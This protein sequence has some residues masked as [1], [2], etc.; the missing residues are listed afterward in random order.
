MADKVTIKTVAKLANVSHT[1]VSRAL[2]GSPLV[3]EETRKKIQEIAT[4]LDYTPNLNAKAL[5]EKRSYIIAVYF[6]D[7]SN[8]TS[9]SFMSEV[10]HQIREK[11]PKG[12]EI[13]VDSFAALR[14]SGQ[15][16]NLRYDGALVV[17]QEK[18][19]DQF[20]DQL[21]E[22]GKPVVVLNRKVERTDL[23][24]YASDDFSGMENAINYLLRMGHRKIAFITG[25]KGFTS[26]INRKAAFVDVMKK[27][28]VSV[29]EEWMIAGD[30]SIESGYKAMEKIINGGKIP[31]C[32]YASNDDMAIGAIRACNDYGYKVPGQISFMGFDDSIFANYFTPRLTTLKKQ[33]K[34]IVDRGISTLKSLIDGEQPTEK[35]FEN[36][37][38]TLVI[39]ESVAKLE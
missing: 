4:R 9:P 12:Y 21:A 24:N 31:T 16:I 17:S 30:Y 7:I 8:G 28:Q 27:N 6:S 19:D 13:A 20:I 39:R 33:T 29:P 22:T 25:K 10:I 34:M 18:T 32:V 14:R 38:P 11:L 35:R 26:S 1:T 37:K 36:I 23:Y 2:N 5:V 3:K 15:G